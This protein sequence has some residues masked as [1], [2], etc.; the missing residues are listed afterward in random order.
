MEVTVH[1][2]REKYPSSVMDESVLYTGR[3]PAR[4]LRYDKPDDLCF[5]DEAEKG[6]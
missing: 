3:D 1:T 2:A 5:D 6:V 4:Q